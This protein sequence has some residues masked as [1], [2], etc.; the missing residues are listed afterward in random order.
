[1]LHMYINLNSSEFLRVQHGRVEVH[2][3][4]DILQMV[5]VLL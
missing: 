2:K 3:L 4:G 5:V 1:M